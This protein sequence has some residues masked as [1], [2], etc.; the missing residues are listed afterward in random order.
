MDRVHSAKSS[1]ENVRKRIAS[2]VADLRKASSEE[3]VI[4]VPST[5]PTISMHKVEP[6]AVPPLVAAISTAPAADLKVDHSSSR[7]RAS[8]AQASAAQCSKNTPLALLLGEHFPFKLQSCMQQ[9]PVKAMVP[10]E[11]RG[12]H[13]YSQPRVSRTKVA[14]DPTLNQ[15]TA[16]HVLDDGLS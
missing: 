15:K 5:I 10:Y 3:A 6:D 8:A 9:R 16:R 14:T 2:I 7:A 1:L 13:L 4:V 12:S 11:R